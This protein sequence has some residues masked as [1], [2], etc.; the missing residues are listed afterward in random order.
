MTIVVVREAPAGVS[1]V[2]FSAGP[3][4]TDLTAVTGAA[5]AVAGA[6]VDGAVWGAYAPVPGAGAAEAVAGEA[7]G[8]GAAGAG[9]AGA[10]LFSSEK[11]GAT[12]ARKAPRTR[13][14]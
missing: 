5:E 14:T 6:S 7:A 3:F 11:A 10:G 9:A 8:A 1:A 4:V 2:V 12:T 13:T